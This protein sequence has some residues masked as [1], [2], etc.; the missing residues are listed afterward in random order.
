MPIS[1]SKIN[2]VLNIAFKSLFAGLAEMLK[3]QK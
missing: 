2:K 3:F 1:V